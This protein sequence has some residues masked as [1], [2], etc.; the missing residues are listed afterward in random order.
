MHILCEHFCSYDKSLDEEKGRIRN[1]HHQSDNKF[2]HR[3]NTTLILKITDTVMRLP[4]DKRKK[5]NTVALSKN[6][7][8]NASE[9]QSLTAPSTLYKCLAQQ[10]ANPLNPFFFSFSTDQLWN[11]RQQQNMT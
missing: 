7:T 4:P 3:R 5:E 10:E 8:Q 11:K 6:Q 9:R 2:A 1:K